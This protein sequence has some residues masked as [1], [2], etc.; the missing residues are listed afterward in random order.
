MRAALLR[1]GLLLAACAGAAQEAPRL[2][3]W[4]RDA[5][6]A[7]VRGADAD[8]PI[9]VGSIQKPFV[10]EAW[11]ASHAG[12]P[13][14]RFRCGPASGCWLPAGHGELGLGRAMALS[15]NT[16]FRQLAAQVPP[17][18]LGAALQGAG[19]LRA[20]RSPEE[21]I[22]LP[23][24]E[25][26]L[27]VRPQDLLAAYARLVRDPWPV[28]EPIRA[29]VLEGLREAALEGTAKGLGWRGFWVKTGTVPSPDGN[30]LHTCGLALAVDDAGWAMLARLDPG[31]GRDAAL[32]MSGEV[33]RLRPWSMAHATKTLRGVRSLAQIESGSVRVRLFD[34]VASPRW[35]ARNLGDAPMAFGGAFL[36]PG[37]AQAL[38]AGDRLG[39]GLIEI[40]SSDSG[41][42]RRFFGRLACAAGRAGAL[43]LIATL[44]ARDYVSGVV[45]AELPQGSP[46]LRE[47][48]GAAVLRFLAKGPRHGDADVCDD[49][50]CAWFV[51][52]GPRLDWRDPRHAAE[53][54]GDADPGFTDEAWARILEAAQGPGPSQWT[55]H[56]GGEPLSP[57]AL[58][59]GP[60]RAVTP[61]PRHG[62]EASDPW[63][64]RWP[65][66]AL[67]KAFGAPV[68]GLEVAADEGTWILRVRTARG[69][70]A[71]RYDEAHRLL[72][73]ALGWDAL[74]SPADRV[75]PSEGGFRA[76]GRG[77]GH[78]V[79]LCLA[80]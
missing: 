62:P 32:A 7:M 70:R 11:S 60:D 26:P 47:Q 53:A 2:Q 36:G 56:C 75:E 79:G 52:R 40:R 27:R 45:A 28:G 25:G 72:A 78:R 59:G 35:E 37:G 23:G 16:Y 42:R 65:A 33:A 64:R 73:K 57:H 39:P 50:H 43:R 6:G 24:P 18:A 68:L 4:C 13:P 38:H 34:L 14:P 74:P 80:E 8:A 48:L 20:P 55:A 58:W 12:A 1:A 69:E 3:I 63:T 30:P 54:S 76:M 66:P 71:C 31:T 22:G 77:S 67:E 10:A 19:F 17:D 46:G 29:Q 51:G 44:A 41:A 61:C 15:C 49:T 9:A 21:A 5:A